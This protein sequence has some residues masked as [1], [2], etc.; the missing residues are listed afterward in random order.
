MAVYSIKD[1]EKLTGIRAHTIRIWEQR[2][3]L[4]EPSRTDTNIRYYQDED[5]KFLINVS[6]LNRNGLKISKIAAL[7]KE[8]IS[9]KV[10]E[11]TKQGTEFETRLDALTIAMIEMNEPVFD[12]IISDYIR[13]IG[14]ERTMTELLYPFLDK[15]GALWLTG[16]INHVQESFIS[17]IIRR[18]VTVAI[19]AEPVLPSK[20][21][22]RFLIFLPAGETQ[23]LSLLF[24]HYL[25]KSRGQSVLYLGQNTTL[26]DLHLAGEI[27]DPDYVFTIITEAP[28]RI[29]VEDYLQRLSGIFPDRRVLLSGYQVMAR[30]VDMPSN[31]RILAGLDDTLSFLEEL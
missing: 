13:D 1:L 15:L 16:S 11:I 14:F 4:L 25:L 17:Y 5:L 6:L 24:M 29:T 18:K 20:D 23:E 9:K 27:Y 8:E 3:G 19:D 7:S 28:K 21:G 31:A 30:Q 26:S 10:R 22:K 12:K 2:Y